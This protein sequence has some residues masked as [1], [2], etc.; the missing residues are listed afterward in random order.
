MEKLNCGAFAT[1]PSELSQVE[2]RG[3]GLTG[4][5]L[6]T[7]LS[8]SQWMQLLPGKGHNLEQTAEGQEQV[9]FLEFGKQV[10]QS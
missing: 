7:S 10:P 4:Y 2:S 6:D 3:P 8:S 1:K 9:I 5:L